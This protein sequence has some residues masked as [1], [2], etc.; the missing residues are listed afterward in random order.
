MVMLNT[1]N[2]TAR[3]ILWSLIALASTGFCGGGAMLVHGHFRNG[4]R[5]ATLETKAGF[6]EQF[7]VDL[8]R[9]G[10]QI[11]LLNQVTAAM[12]KDIAMQKDTYQEWREEWKEWRKSQQK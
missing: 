12:A 1:N 9:I 4:E 11:G 3:K 7:S 2:G 8:K 5:L 10:E 6:T